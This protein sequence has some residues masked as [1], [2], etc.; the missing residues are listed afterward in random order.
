MR[1]TILVAMTAVVLTMA[2]ARAQT[3][4]AR[5]APEG[6]VKLRSLIG[7]WH[8]TA[9]LD[10]TGNPPVKVNVEVQCRQVSGGSGVACDTHMSWPGT[11]CL[12]ADLFGWNAETGQLHW[13]SV[14]SAGEVHDH[15]GTFE[16]SKLVV[17][18]TGSA[19]GQLLTE[20]V[21]LDLAG[22]GM[23]FESVSHVGG[24][25]TATLRGKATRK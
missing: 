9:E 21:T 15:V 22:G 7:T 2:S 1:R 19:G 18:Y 16:G 10:E 25:L 17:R 20:D 14:T 8:G 3:T 11:D 6:L 5:Q 24:A 4:P 23:A 13:Y 12:E